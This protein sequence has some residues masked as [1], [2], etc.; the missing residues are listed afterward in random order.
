MRKLLCSL[1][2]LALILAAVGGFAASKKVVYKQVPKTTSGKPI[3]K[4]SI[5]F[6]G[7]D[8]HSLAKL[9]SQNHLTY[10]MNQ[11]LLNAAKQAKKG[12]YVN[13]TVD[14]IPYFSSWFI[15]GSRNS[16]YP[17]S[18]VGQSPTAG[19]T[20]TVNNQIIPLISVLTVGGAPIY[21]FDPTTA[22]DAQG[23]ASVP[24]AGPGNDTGLLSQSPLYDATTTYPGP[25]PQT[26]QINDTAQRTAFAPSAA[27][28]WHTLLG[29]PSSSGIVWIQFLE[30]NN[31]DWTCLFGSGP[32]CDTSIGDFPVF[33]INT[34]SLNFAFILAVEAPPNNTVPIIVTDFLTAFDPAGGCC[35]LGYHTAQTG[36]VDPSGILV[37]TWGTWIPYAA[38]NGFTNP[39]GAF[40]YNSFVL[41]H[42]VSELFNDPFVNTSVSPWVDGSV[43]FAQANLETGDAVEAMASAD[44]VYPVPLNTTGGPFDYNLQTVAILPWFTRNPFNGGI[45]SWPNEGA[46]SHAPHPV[47]CNT[48]F[49]CWSYGE[50]SAGFFFGPPY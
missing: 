10:A 31:G 13:G 12:S 24:S 11:K 7:F 43:S 37:W 45:Y 38:D 25:P 17:Y 6:Q 9:K 21:V 50:G 26:G 3:P 16:V 41:S 23:A 46:L 5:K 35:V 33:N 39:F 34:I 14:T 44:S 47:G 4:G 2:I 15:T 28:N 20:T 48:F 27:A 40:G 32:P 36:I 49:T 18:M 30:F 19:G 29:A 1:T 22:T 8:S 42:E